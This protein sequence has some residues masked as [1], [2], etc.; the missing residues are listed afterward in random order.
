V[1]E[2]DALAGSVGGMHAM[3]AYVHAVLTD[4]RKGRDDE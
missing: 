4:V 1:R 3:S 2:M